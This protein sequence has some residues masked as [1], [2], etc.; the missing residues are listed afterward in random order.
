[1]DGRRGYAYLRCLRQS[2][3]NMSKDVA[4]PKLQA[5]PLQRSTGFGSKVF[6][7]GRPYPNATLARTPGLRMANLAPVFGGRRCCTTKDVLNGY[8]KPRS[9]ATY[10]SE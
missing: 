7:N 3:S 2:V 6:E 4:G 9:C 10:L 8:H 5:Q 1:M